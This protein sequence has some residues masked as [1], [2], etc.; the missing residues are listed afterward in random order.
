MAYH[1]CYF[2]V[3]PSIAEAPLQVTF[4]LS[5]AAVF[6]TL[7]TLL[8]HSTFS[9][10]TL[11]LLPPQTLLRDFTMRA[12]VVGFAPGSFHTLLVMQDGSVW[13]TGVRSDTDCKGF[14][15]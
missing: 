9:L 13:S 5:S 4:A 12:G 14:V 1:T 8:L 15:R 11:L 3:S 10:P 6:T 7:K 2:Q